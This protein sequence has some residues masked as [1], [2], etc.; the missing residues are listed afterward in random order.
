MEQ[1]P[2]VDLKAQYQSIKEEI[3]SAISNVLDNS[4]FIGG[5]GLN[6][7]SLSLESLLGINH[8]LP[9]ANGTDAIYVALKQLGIGPGDEVITSAHSW[10][11]TSETI[12]QTGAHPIFVDTNEF[13]CL[14]ET[15]IEDRI[16]SKT[17][18]IIPVHLY[19][20]PC[21]M[22]KIC[23]TA[24]KHNLA[25]VEDC[26][27]A[28][29]TKWSGKNVGTFGNAG[30]ISFFPG[31]NLGAYGDAGAIVTNDKSLFKNMKMYS[32]HGSLKKHDHIIEG[33]NS[34]MDT[35]QAE[36]LNVKIKYID[37]WINLRRSAAEMY[38][39]HLEGIEEIELPEVA[40]EA[41]HSY[42]LFVIKT[43]N[44]DHLSSYLKEKNISTGIHYPKALPMLECYK[45]LDLNLEE[46]PNACR[47]SE[48]ILSLP[49]FPE[50]TEEQIIYISRN[51]RNYFLDSKVL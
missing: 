46:F 29:L 28:I 27:Q 32:N 40:D 31:K 25:I 6:R 15:L 12:S 18:A 19:G 47:N 4:S 23:E 13:Y 11:S 49:I 44:R 2:F 48:A 14:D 20:H 37:K 10:I 36:I 51:I 43:D 8:A 21:N 45:Y 39:K 3:D 41:Y 17:K 38:R 30:T 35:L 26:A 16:N 34:R 7:F 42:H 50:I 33:I 9:V 1:I 22:T 5:E 24:R